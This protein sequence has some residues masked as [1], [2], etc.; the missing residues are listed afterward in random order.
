SPDGKRLFS[1]SI[2]NTIKVW[3][4]DSGKETVTL[5]TGSVHR[6][7]LSV[8]GKRLFCSRDRTITVWDL[9]CGKETLT[10]RG[11]TLDVISLALSV[12]GSSREAATVRSRCGT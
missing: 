7:A 2:D 8:D 9:D 10:L 5:Q 1:A 6:L 11:H 4:L 3:D 12:S